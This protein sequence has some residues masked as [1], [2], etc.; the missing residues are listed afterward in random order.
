M[1]STMLLPWRYSW[2]QSL[3]VKNQI[4]HPFAT[5]ANGKEGLSRNTYGSDIVLTLPVSMLGV[6]DPCLGSNLGILVL[7]KTE[8]A[9]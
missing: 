1:T 4:S 5:F 2:L 9:A 3:S 6:V 7:I 8:P